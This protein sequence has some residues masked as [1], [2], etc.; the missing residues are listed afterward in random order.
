MGRHCSKTLSA[1]N[2]H[3]SAYLHGE[4]VGHKGKYLS[5]RVLSQRPGSSGS[6]GSGRYWSLADGKKLAA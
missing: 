6:V 3:A 1:K 4:D 5:E 2:E